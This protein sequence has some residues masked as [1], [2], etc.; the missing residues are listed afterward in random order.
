[1]CSRP[2]RL[3][4]PAEPLFILVAGN[5]PAGFARVD[6]VG[7]QAHLEQLSVHPDSASRGIGMSLVNAAIDVAR[8]RGYESM[9]LCTFA[10][11]RNKLKLQVIYLYVRSSK[12]DGR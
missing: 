11:V 4:A 5:P 12:I 10:D 1:M 2:R 7:G 6:E 3:S 8:S 9:P